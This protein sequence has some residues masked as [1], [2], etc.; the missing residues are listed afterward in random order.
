MNQTI[1]EPAPGPKSVSRSQGNLVTNC[2]VLH[3]RLD[4]LD[5]A[6]VSVLRSP[7][8]TETGTKVP[9]PEC[10]LAGTID[11]L[12]RRVSQACHRIEDIINRLEL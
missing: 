1:A 12:G 2:D 10:Q 7:G 11:D 8:P 3:E 6:L 5:K 4:E 9:E